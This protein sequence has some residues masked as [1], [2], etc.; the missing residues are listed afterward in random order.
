MIETLCERVGSNNIR[1]KSLVTEVCE[2]E[3][4]RMAVLLN[5]G[6]MIA[7][8]KVIMAIPLRVAATTLHL[9]WAA[10]SLLETMRNTPTWMSTHAKA[11]VLYERPFWRELGL[12]GR[13]ASQTG[14]LVEVH[15]HSSADIQSAALFGFVGW[16]AAQRQSCP[17][18]LQQEILKQLSDCF[19]DAAANPVDLVIQDWAL[20][21]HIVTDLDL[22]ET[23]QHPDVGP[24]ILTENHLNGRI[25]FA[26]SEMSNRSPG[27]IE[28]ALVAGESAATEMLDK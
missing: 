24:K 26:V 16:S 2:Y 27:L 19:G 7:A 4:D 5:T 12:S 22:S 28:G 8:H 11:V 21:T 15:D 9:P 25:R 13:V 10:Q 14:P 18:Q 1:T 23:Q 17:K 3:A 20:N 6:E